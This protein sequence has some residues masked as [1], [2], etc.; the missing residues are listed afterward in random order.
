MFG[1]TSFAQAPF[2][3]LGV[4]YD[5][6]LSENVTIDN[7]QTITAQFLASFTDNITVDD[8]STQSSAFLQFVTENSDL[9]DLLTASQLQKILY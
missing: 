5:L 1:F 2:A 4:G 3:A 9:A 6:A 8:S 7:A